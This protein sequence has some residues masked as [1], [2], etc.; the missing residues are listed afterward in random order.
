[1]LFWLPCHK[2][3]LQAYIATCCESENEVYLISCVCVWRWDLVL[4]WLLFITGN[5]HCVYQNTVESKWI[6]VKCQHMEERGEGNKW[7]KKKVGKLHM[8]YSTKVI[9]KQNKCRI[10]VQWFNLEIIA[11]RA[12][13]QPSTCSSRFLWNTIDSRFHLMGFI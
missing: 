4:K 13:I 8:H 6:Q 3:Q 12:E 11:I 9:I 5:T 7:R 2:T 1:M 10:N